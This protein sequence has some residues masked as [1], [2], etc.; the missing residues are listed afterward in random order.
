MIF[1][2]VVAAIEICCGVIGAMAATGLEVVTGIARAGML[3]VG[4]FKDF[5]DPLSPVSLTR[6]TP[7]PF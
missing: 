6:V 3:A 1:C 5:V 2:V 7:L 4:T